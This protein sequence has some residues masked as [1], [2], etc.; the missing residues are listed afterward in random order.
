MKP[1]SKQ[2]LLL[3][4]YTFYSG[5]TKCKLCI[6]S[7]LFYCFKNILC[8]VVLCYTLMYCSSPHCGGLRK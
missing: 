3:E 7:L 6:F 1:L 4:L 2:Y 5:Y 8:Y